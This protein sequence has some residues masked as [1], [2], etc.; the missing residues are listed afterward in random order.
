MFC[1]LARLVLNTCWREFNPFVRVERFV[2]IERIERFVRIERFERFV[3][4]EWFV[5][6][7]RIVELVLCLDVLAARDSLC[8]DAALAGS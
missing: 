3:R 5:R 1:H 6:I 7:E 8:C 4:I 2:R